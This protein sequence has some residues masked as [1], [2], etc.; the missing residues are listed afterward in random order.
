MTNSMRLQFLGTGGYHP[1]ER[2]HTACVWLPDSGLVFDAGSAAFRLQSRLRTVELDIFLTHAHLDHVSGLTNFIV[3]F[4]TGQL[5]RA[6]V[7]AR[8]PYLDDVQTHL[9]SQPLFPVNPGFEYRELPRAVQLSD[10][11]MVT[12]TPLVH[13]GGST[14]FRVDWPGKSLAYI[15]DTTAGPEYL[16]FIRGVDLLIHECNFSDALS[17]W[18]AK[19]GHSNTTPVAELARQAE[20]KQLYLTH[21]DPQHPED[22]PIGIE[23]AR[24]IFPATKMAEDLLEIEF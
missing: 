2:R 4:L 10:G 5:Q 8:Q 14:G 12:H 11:G 21:I 17:Q 23:T 20:V 6:T 1:N 24:A 18:S 13:P 22:D 19:S 9:F 7:H 15:T 3:P 16:E